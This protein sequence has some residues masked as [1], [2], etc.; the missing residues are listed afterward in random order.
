MAKSRAD[1]C[2]SNDDTEDGYLDET[3]PD[4]KGYESDPTENSTPV[5]TRAPL[6]NHLFAQGGNWY[7]KT[8]KS[9]EGQPYFRPLNGK[10]ITD[11]DH[12]VTLDNG[13]ALRNSDLTFRIKSPIAPNIFKKDE[14]LVNVDDLAGKIMKHSAANRLESNKVGRFFSRRTLETSAAKRRKS[15]TSSSKSF[16]SFASEPTST[17]LDHWDNNLDLDHWDNILEGYVRSDSDVNLFL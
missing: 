16:I 9:K 1:D 17:Y 10:K 2:G 14:Y 11:I 8:V 15:H 7:R 6:S 4:N 5:T 12:T 3:R 13:H